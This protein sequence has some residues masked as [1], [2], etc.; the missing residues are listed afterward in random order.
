MVL[1]R[2]LAIRGGK[3]SRVSVPSTVVGCLHEG[4]LEIVRVAIGHISEVIDDT[5][6]MVAETHEVP[7]LHSLAATIAESA[8]KCA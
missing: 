8:R 7:F 3:F 4:V 2:D 5:R 1:R 6:T